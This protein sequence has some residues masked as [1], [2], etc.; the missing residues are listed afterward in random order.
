MALVSPREERRYFY[1]LALAPADARNSS[2]EAADDAGL[3]EYHAFPSNASMVSKVPPPQVLEAERAVVM[4][5]GGENWRSW[6][7]VS[8]F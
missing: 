3:G 2:Y 7:P 8:D 6:E 4:E 5:G 1:S